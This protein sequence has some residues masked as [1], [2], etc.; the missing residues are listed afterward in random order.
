MRITLGNLQG[1]GWDL[2]APGAPVYLVEDSVAGF[3]STFQDTM[4]SVAGMPGGWANPLDR[5]I[6]PI[7]GEFSVVCETA[8][9]ARRFIESLTVADPMRLDWGERYL[10]VWLSELPALPGSDYLG[11]REVK[12]KFVGREGVWRGPTENNVT[13][14]NTGDVPV[15]PSIVWFGECEVTT[16]SGARFTLPDI[17]DSVLVLLTQPGESLAVVESTLPPGSISNF[18]LPYQT[19]L[20][21][22][23]WRDVRRVALAECVPV[24]EVAS[25]KLSRGSLL[26]ECCYFSPVV[27]DD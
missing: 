21:P 3:V 10:I 17:P 25:W 19:R 27:A 7:E 2:T 18:P 22:N 14:T 9:V 20:L 4:L 11:A 23:V 8:A 12:L 24:G 5:V 16:P 15:W 6:P 26:W 1:V 13:V